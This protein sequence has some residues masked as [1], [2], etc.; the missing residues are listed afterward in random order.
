MPMISAVVLFCYDKFEEAPNEKV[1]NMS[2]LTKPHF[3]IPIDFLLIYYIN[4]YGDY[5]QKVGI[6][7][8][9]KWKSH[10]NKL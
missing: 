10:D 4:V 9:I 8:N 6:T 2:K 1:V 7:N 3:S 5:L